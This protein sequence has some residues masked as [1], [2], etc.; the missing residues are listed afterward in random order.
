MTNALLV[1]FGVLTLGI[2]ALLV[3]RR[4]AA[5]RIGRARE[6]L[7]LTLL[8]EMDSVVGPVLEGKAPHPVDVERFAAA[9][10]TRTTLFDFLLFH[11]RLNLFP[12]AY[13]TVEALAESQ[14]VFWLDHPNEL[15]SP[16]DE[17]ELAEEVEIEARQSGRARWL[18]FRFRVN[19]PHWA[20]GD[21][22][23]AGVVGPVSRRHREAFPDAPV[24]WSMFR[25]FGSMS[26]AD[27]ARA[28]RDLARMSGVRV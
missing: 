14:L 7:L 8:D 4:V 13:R 23:V 17:I 10:R 3:W 9:A 12:A 26:P 27:H 2:V 15:G 5:G 28:C 24:V 22:W 18:V 16:P 1:A 25:P 19:P 6:R 21:G 11:K 20:A